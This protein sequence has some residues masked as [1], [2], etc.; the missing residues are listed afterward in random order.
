MV[1]HAVW[2]YLGQVSTRAVRTSHPITSKSPIGPRYHSPNQ[3]INLNSAAE[4]MVA[5]YTMGIHLLSRR[6]V[7]HWQAWWIRVYFC[8]ES[9]FTDRIHR[10][11]PDTEGS[12]QQCGAHVLHTSVHLQLFLAHDRLTL[13]SH[14]ITSTLQ[15]QSG[16]LVITTYVIGSTWLRKPKHMHRL[17]K[18]YQSVL[19]ILC[20]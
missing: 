2:R 3:Y 15:Y 11:E 10:H 19:A 13:V 20:V 1:G 12:E 4:L 9:K 18:P 7:S 5:Y 16:Y 6:L 14:Q 8:L 17:S